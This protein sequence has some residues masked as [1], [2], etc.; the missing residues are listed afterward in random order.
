MLIFVIHFKFN[1][2]VVFYVTSW[3]KQDS[4]YIYFK[5]FLNQLN[6]LYICIYLYVQQMKSYEHVS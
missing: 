4:T 1:F 3:S 6:L 2:H 5:E